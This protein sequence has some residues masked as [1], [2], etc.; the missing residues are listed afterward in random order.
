MELLIY[1]PKTIVPLATLVYLLLF[2]SRRADC[3]GAVATGPSG[4][5]EPPRT[6]KDLFLKHLMTKYLHPMLRFLRFSPVMVEG[7]VSCPT[8]LVTG[9][10]TQ[11]IADFVV[12]FPPDTYRVFEFLTHATRH[13]LLRGA[14]YALRVLQIHSGDG[15]TED[16]SSGITFIYTR[17]CGKLPPKD[18]AVGTGLEGRCVQLN[19]DRFRLDKMVDLH[20]I[21]GMNRARIEGKESCPGEYV[22][23]DD[24]RLVELVAPLGKVEGDLGKA[25][26]DYF[27]LAVAQLRMTGDR[28]HFLDMVNGAR[29]GG[30]ADSGMTRRY[31]K[32][33]VD[34]GYN[35]SD[36]VAE[37]AEDLTGWDF[38]KLLKSI[39]TKDVIIKSKDVIIKSKDEMIKS[40]DE[41]N[42][43]LASE[44]E[45]LASEKETLASEKETLASEKET[46]AS[47][48]EDSNK[49]AVL[50]LHSVGISPGKISEM[51]GL[52]PPEVSRILS[53]NG[54]AV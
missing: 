13:D 11:R 9:G 29:A 25:G 23:S 21:I 24:E 40:K 26:E 28:H 52:S 35:L 3:S 31:A 50:A 48:V 15:R 53:G 4:Y 41:E 20:E 1:I 19:P 30:I 36:D 33:Y 38:R 37:F 7:A 49:T 18:F 17:G 32:E 46:L 16:L 39:E 8:E 51:M 34:M 6:I 10:M 44:K 47:K 43:A 22:L 42:K 14:D 54:K 5:P 2:R 45:A 27:D 12:R